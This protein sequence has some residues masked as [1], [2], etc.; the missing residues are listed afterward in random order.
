MLPLTFVSH[1]GQDE[2]YLTSQLA[3]SIA[4]LLK[5]PRVPFFFDARSLPSGVLWERAI[6]FSAAGAQVFVAI[7]H[8]SYCRHYWCM[9][10]LDIAMHTGS[11]EPGQEGY[12]SYIR[13]AD[14]RQAQR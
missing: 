9:R 4:G 7:V 13:R 1:T 12:H 5:E 6:K 8:P 10:E 3:Q 11:R 14:A 2:K